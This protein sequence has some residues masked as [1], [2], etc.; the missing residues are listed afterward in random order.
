[1]VLKLRASA[2]FRVPSVY[3]FVFGLC[4]CCSPLSESHRLLFCPRFQPAEV[5]S[6]AERVV[7]NAAVIRLL[8]EQQSVEN[9]KAFYITCHAIEDK[10]EALVNIYGTITVGQAIIFCKTRKDANW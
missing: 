6:F 8:R 3:C 7:P 9:I 2:L 1:M 10:F 5:I 4:S